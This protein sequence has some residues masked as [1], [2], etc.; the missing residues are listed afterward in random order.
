MEDRQEKKESTGNGAR[1][2]SLELQ[3]SDFFGFFYEFQISI[4]DCCL[5]LFRGSSF[6]FSGFKYESQIARLPHHNKEHQEYKEY[7]KHKEHKEYREK[8]KHEE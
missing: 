8:E 6:G 2:S 5:G 3:I 7:K 1:K 4:S